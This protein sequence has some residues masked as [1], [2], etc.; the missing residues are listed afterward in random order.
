MMIKY[1]NNNEHNIVSIDRGWHHWT[2]GSCRWCLFVVFD[3]NRQPSTFH[4]TTTDAVV[5]R[6][7]SQASL[8][9]QLTSDYLSHHVVMHA[10]VPDDHI[11]II[12]LLLLIVVFVT[13]GLFYLLWSFLVSILYRAHC[14]EIFLNTRLPITTMFVNS[15]TA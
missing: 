15:G 12:L 4:S 11:I 5:A 3:T 8:P 1:I 13:R 14:S 2:S 6:S 10:L 7:K 9:Q